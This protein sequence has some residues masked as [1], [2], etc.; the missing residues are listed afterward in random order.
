MSST[1]TGKANDETGLGSSR[2]FCTLFPVVIR[3]RRTR[4]PL[5][6]EAPREVADIDDILETSGSGDDSCP[7]VPCSSIGRV[8]LDITS[9]Q[10]ANR[11]E[12]AVSGAGSAA[13]TGTTTDECA[14][15]VLIELATEDE[16]MAEAAPR[17]RVKH[18]SPPRLLG[19]DY[20]KHGS[21]RRAGMWS[22]A[23]WRGQPGTPPW[24]ARRPQ[25]Q[26][27]SARCW[28]GG[29][30]L[31]AVLVREQSSFDGAA[32]AVQGVL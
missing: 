12:S 2:S 3:L 10:A 20:L 1:F 25:T 28:S 4:L 6:A 18:F 31:P 30:N 21:H 29:G 17:R 7:V 9:R 27:Q 23:M 5:S 24:I 19:C 32:E 15:R 13:C 11:P 26:R 14:Q 8:V 16:A 22:R